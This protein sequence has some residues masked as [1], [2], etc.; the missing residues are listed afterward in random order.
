MKLTENN[1]KFAVV[2]T[3]FHGG[4]TI[5]FSNSLERAI[6]IEKEHTVSGCSCGCCSVVPVT[7]Q[8][9]K[10]INNYK[11]KYG[12]YVYCCDR[13]YNEYPVYQANGEPY[14]QLCR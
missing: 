10:E 14:G 7:E 2:R 8:A 1:S 13:L 9:R 4:G 12:E 3:A 6:K 11:N 5:A